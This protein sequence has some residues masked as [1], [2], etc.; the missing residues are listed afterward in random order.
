[1]PVRSR[2]DVSISLNYEICAYV[3]YMLLIDWI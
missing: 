1:M 3:I 2:A